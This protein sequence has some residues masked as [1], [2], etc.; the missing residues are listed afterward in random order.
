MAGSQPRL[1]TWIYSTFSATFHRLAAK[2]LTREI[3]GIIPNEVYTVDVELRP[4]NVVLQKGE[5]LV[6][7]IGA[8]ELAGSGLFQHNGPSDR[9]ESVFKG[10]N[11][12]HFGPNYENWISLPVNPSSD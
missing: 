8:S 10:N 11:H 4:T 9:P 3:P 5:R 12:V 1:Q 2:C 7:D 6:S